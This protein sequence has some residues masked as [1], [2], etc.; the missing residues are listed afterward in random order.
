[1]WYWYYNVDASFINSTLINARNQ[2]LVD[3]QVES[4]SPLRF[5]VATVTNTGSYAK[6]WWWYYGVTGT[7]LQSLVNQNNARMID[8]DS[9][10]DAN[11]NQRFATIMIRN[12]GNDAKAWWYYYNVSPSFVAGRIT[13]NN[14]RLTDINYRPNGNLDVIMVPNTGVDAK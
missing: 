2:R 6:T 8:L 10:T 3:L 1:G 12:T 13:A 11:G 14:A 7:G 4:V 9:Y 5:D